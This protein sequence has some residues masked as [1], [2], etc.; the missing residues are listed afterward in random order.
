MQRQSTDCRPFG[1][2][3]CFFF[4]VCLLLLAHRAILGE[5][6]KYATLHQSLSFLVCVLR[7]P[8]RHRLGGLGSAYAGVSGIVIATA[9]KDLTP[10]CFCIGWFV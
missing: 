7:F 5:S 4:H 2:S 10:G 9:A 6:G 1:R 8:Y 3:P